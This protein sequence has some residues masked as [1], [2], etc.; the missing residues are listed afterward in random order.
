[1]GVGSSL[2]LLLT[3][4]EAAELASRS[5]R[6]S[7]G[8]NTVSRVSGRL[9]RRTSSACLRLKYQVWSLIFEQDCI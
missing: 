6:F 4:D 2:L 3:L 9:V 1:M 7:G 5:S 8:R